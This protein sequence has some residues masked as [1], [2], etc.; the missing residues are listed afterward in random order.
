[1]CVYVLIYIVNIYW[2]IMYI[3][4]YIVIHRQTVTLSYN[5]SV[6][7]DIQDASTGYQNSADFTSVNIYIYIYIYILHTSVKRMY[8]NN[9]NCDS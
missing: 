6:W 2:M 1:M 7:F 3:Y 4:I 5:S 9:S 8:V